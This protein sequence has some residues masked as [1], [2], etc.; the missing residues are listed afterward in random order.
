M[1]FNIMKYRIAL[2]GCLLFIALA[3]FLQ[4]TN[5]YHFLFI[6]QNQLFLFSGSYIGERIV[7]PGG[8]AL[9]VGEFLVQFFILPYVGAVVTALLLTGVGVLTALICKRIA[10]ASSLYL[11]YFLPVLSLL[12]MHFDFNYQIQGT[13]A[14]LFL[15]LF[16]YL[17]LSVGA[18]R[19]RLLMA[20]FVVPLLYWLGGPVAC[21]YACC[22]FLWEALNRS[23]GWYWTLPVVVEA[24]VIAWVNVYV[25]IVSDYKF[26]FLP[27]IYFHTK[28]AAPFC[29]YYS[30]LSLPVV[31]AGAYLL[32]GRE[33]AKKKT[34]IIADAAQVLLI[35]GLS[36]ISIPAYNN[37]KSV[38][39]KQLDYYTRTRQWDKVI[40]H[41][42]GRL[43][44]YL[45]LCYLNMA[46]SEK[47]M[48]AEKA[49]TFDQRDIQGL[50]IPWNKTASA[51][52]LLS[53]V[54]FTAGTVAIAQ[55]KAFE[56]YVSSLGY[57]NPR[58]LQ[59]LV[60]TNLIYGEY[61]VAEKYLDL[62]DKT[63][64]Y[65]DWAREHRTFL[66]NDAE[67]EKDMALGEKRR[68]LPEANYLSNPDQLEKDLLSV[69][70]QY[71][72][73]RKA[74][75]YVGVGYLLMKDLGA[76]ENLL[77]SYYTTD[78]AASLPVSFQE[79]VIILYEATP[80]R[81]THYHV[82]ESIVRRF[83]DFKGLIKTNRDNPP[84]AEAA[85]LFGDTYWFYYMFK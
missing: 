33:P 74:I 8:V 10:P 26:A 79:A 40:E 5:A 24:A 77:N 67:V 18:F 62:L 85:R 50:F 63:F 16:I 13:V 30:W 19:Y 23:R 65:S 78:A 37:T 82:S 61:P 72:E 48:L 73:G 54:H 27:D 38:K 15:L 11:F 31:I 21:L 55:E 25:A 64:Y 76:F 4:G 42:T 47:G 75:E 39:L 59:R 69:A 3:L 34:R 83:A 68:G 53:D 12:F 9:L 58:M 29:I 14:F 2:F 84:V 80:E 36:W 56:S 51:S 20:V 35:V 81:W 32:R 49:F 1:A 28:L 45:Y 22:V 43:N 70:R 41:C 71:P 7:A 6:E 57:G 46:L 44:N 60:Q 66:Y 17:Y 52:T